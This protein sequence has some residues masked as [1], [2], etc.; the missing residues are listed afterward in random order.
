MLSQTY[1]DREILESEY[2]CHFETHKTLSRIDLA[3]SSVEGLAF[4]SDVFLELY[5]IILHW[6]LY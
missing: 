3:L 2:L 5:Q 4:I 6:R 1:G